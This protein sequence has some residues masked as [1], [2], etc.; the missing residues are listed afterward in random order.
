MHGLEQKLADVT[1]HA[2]SHHFAHA[3]L[4]HAVWK[5][6]HNMNYKQDNCTMRIL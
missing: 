4:L 1:V 5:D 3:I 6:S 2:L